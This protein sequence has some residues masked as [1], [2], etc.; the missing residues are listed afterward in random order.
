MAEKKKPL[1]PV[2]N[3]RATT[4]SAFSKKILEKYRKGQAGAFRFPAMI[5]HRHS[6]YFS[7][8]LFNMDPTL[9]I[10]LRIDMNFQKIENIIRADL[11]FTLSGTK[12]QRASI[13]LAKQIFSNTDKRVFKTFSVKNSATVVSEG[14]SN[15][16]LGHIFQKTGISV[17]SYVD[18]L[19]HRKSYTPTEYSRQ[20]FET[21]LKKFST[22]TLSKKGI[23]SSVNTEAEVL[24]LSLPEPAQSGNLFKKYSKGKDR[25]AIQSRMKG[26]PSSAIFSNSF[27]PEGESAAYESAKTELAEHPAGGEALY[28][29]KQRQIEKVLDEVRRI[30]TKSREAVIKK[31][32]YAK[33]S[34][35]A[36]SDPLL[37]LE[38]LTEQVYRNIERRI[39]SERERKGL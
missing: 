7:T 37:D 13:S 27:M 1:E 30:V 9:N 21:L 8:R 36:E 19:F 32:A 31:T 15:L 25:L 16:L 18:S 12:R 11:F 17:R 2:Q 3:D 28:F 26:M 29:F 34:E 10:P 5:F 4:I 20:L 33:A 35:K 6:I 38:R 23:A 22:T 24:H 39:R 14:T